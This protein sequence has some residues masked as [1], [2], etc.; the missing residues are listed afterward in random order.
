[1]Y[2]DLPFWASALF[3]VGGLAAL[4]W[5]SDRFVAGAAALAKALG[6]SSFVVGMVVVG[7]GTSAPELLVSAFSGL[8]GHTNIS[9]GN[10]YG[11]CI[12]N[13]A[14]ILG[15]AALISP[16]AVRR[17]VALAAAPLLLALTVISWYMLSDGALSRAESITLLVLF[18]IV[19]PLYCKFDKGSAG[20]SSESAEDAQGMPVAKAAFWTLV[21][22]AVMIGAS[23][24]L[25][26]G[27]VD[28]A[29]A[30]GVSELLIGLTIVA[31]GTSVPELASAI[32]AARRNE[33]ELVLGNIVGSNIFNTLAVIGIAGSIAPSGEF[34]RYVVLRDMPLLF[35]VTL[36][37]MLFGLNFRSPRSAGRI[38]RWQGAL[39][40]A[41]LVAY[42]A[43]SISQ[44]CQSA[45]IAQ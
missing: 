26:W 5:S 15:V 39:W 9:L 33:A 8:S 4:A 27:A 43:L 3:V 32:A 13:I 31:I 41:V 40:L 34:S 35:A 6:V 18:A 28:M 45:R 38:G 29:R 30:L 19:M 20:A 42:M 16:L 2:A 17:S 11:S 14:G 36:S 22:L 12:F 23:H 10:A 1:M 7:F 24:L 37:I 21:G 25:V 44:E